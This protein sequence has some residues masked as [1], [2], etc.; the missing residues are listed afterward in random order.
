[1]FWNLI[2]ATHIFKERGKFIVKYLIVRNA[3]GM[4]KILAGI[5]TRNFIQQITW[6]WK[7][8]RSSPFL[9]LSRSSEMTTQTLVKKNLSYCQLSYGSYKRELKVVALLAVTC[10]IVE[11]VNKYSQ[12]EAITSIIFTMIT[13]N[14]TFS[15]LMLLLS[16]QNNPKN[17]KVKNK[18]LNDW[19]QLW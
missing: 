19:F 10:S 14:F 11:N 16:S 1:M 6:V 12:T 7:N 3:K 13:T 17:W 18:I 8:S 9:I 2:L 4:W 5:S 15:T